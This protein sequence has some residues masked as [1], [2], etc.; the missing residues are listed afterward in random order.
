MS[1]E[2]H[3]KVAI[4]VGASS[5][6]GRATALSFAEKGAKV[7]LAARTAAALSEAVG[8]IRGGEALARPTDVT[9]RASCEGLIRETRDRFG[10]IDI[11][12][13]AT[14]TNIPQRSL[15]VLTP[16]TWDTMIATN[17]S[18]AFHCTR[19]VLPVMREQKEGLIIYLSTGAVQK[20]DVSGV[21][22]QAS[23]HGMVG[24]A[25]GAMQEERGN[26]I[27]TTVI[28]PGLCDTPLVLKRPAP[29]PPEVM[30][31][32]L[33]PEDVAEACLFVAALPSRAHV[34]ELILLPSGL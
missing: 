17:L 22:Y 5:G 23:K 6:M 19:A 25:H 11:L 18:G 8:A 28:F 34:P 14:G 21:A 7:V 24:L 9:D 4:V 16:D 30:A 10:R 31:K 27:R 1:G 3:G 32:A 26:G 29:T 2:I 20:P 15:Q 33:K 13:Y 12:V